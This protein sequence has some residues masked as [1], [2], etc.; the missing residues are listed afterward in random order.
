M[1]LFLLFSLLTSVVT[2]SARGGSVSQVCSNAFLWS[3]YRLK[4]VQTNF[5]N[6]SVGY[7]SEGKAKENVLYIVQLV[8]KGQYE[9]SVIAEDYGVF[10][11]SDRR[12][13]FLR[14]EDGKTINLLEENGIYPD[15][16]FNQGFSSGHL[17]YRFYP[18][19]ASSKFKKNP[20]IKRE[21]FNPFSSRGGGNLQFQDA[22]RDFWPQ[23]DSEEM[24]RSRLTHWGNGSAFQGI[25]KYRKNGIMRQTEGIFRF[26]Y[27]GADEGIFVVNPLD[28][29]NRVVLYI[30]EYEG[31]F[32]II[33]F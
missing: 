26:N 4:G 19:T 32:E 14:N 33:A 22:W 12:G 1:K 6:G 10:L 25:F 9:S 21:L 31:P 7:I 16:I 27:R 2:S 23:Y 8:R 15:E 29:D 24:A 30:N 18:A 3:K 20:R 5:R 13:V 11:T 17:L 28:S